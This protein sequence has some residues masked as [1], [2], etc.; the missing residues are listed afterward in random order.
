MRYDVLNLINMLSLYK[1][2]RIKYI[3]FSVKF[4]MQQASVH[5]FRTAA[6]RFSDVSY[7][8]SLQL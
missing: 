5:L 2:K 7:F 3:V 4:A 1:S 6:A 8:T